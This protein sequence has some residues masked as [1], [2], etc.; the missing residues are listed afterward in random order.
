MRGDLIDLLA[1]YVAKEKANELLCLI[2]ELCAATVSHPYLVRSMKEERC[3]KC[4]LVTCNDFFVQRTRTPL[5]PDDLLLRDA[6]QARGV[7][8]DVVP[9]EHEAYEWEHTDLVVVR[10][11]WNWHLAHQAYLRWCQRV[12]RAT[13]L[14]NPLRAIEWNSEKYRYFSDLRQ[15]GVPTIPTMF[16][17]R[18]C[19]VNLSWLLDATGWSKV[20]FKPS[21]GANSY[22]TLVVD[23]ADQGS[24]AEGQRQLASLLQERDMLMQPFLEEIVHGG[25]VSHV[26]FQGRWSHAFSKP[27]L[28]VRVGS[29][30]S[31]DEVEQCI[32]AS[33]EEIALA[34][35]ILE[36]AQYILHTDPLVFARVDLVREGDQW[37]CMEL[38]MNEPA[39]HLEANAYR[40]CSQLADAIMTSSA[41]FSDGQREV[42]LG[43]V[44]AV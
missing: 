22:G 44:C 28:Q 31:T 18:S 32:S 17:A 14:L 9:W 13:R 23:Q 33:P 19:R 39:L 30:L 3:M 5:A 12:D 2:R 42:R 38:E 29:G 41:V 36:T 7:Q 10:S 35:S 25:Q 8:V 26:F 6:L 20:I 16:L 40:A 24:L 15:A 11:A 1:P 37:R 4:V 43:S 21:I 27:H 34:T